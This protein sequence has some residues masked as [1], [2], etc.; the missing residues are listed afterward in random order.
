MF[1]FQRYPFSVMVSVGLS[2]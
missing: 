2:V 1:K